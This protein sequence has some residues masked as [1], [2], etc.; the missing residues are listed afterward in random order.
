[1]SPQRA[2]TAVIGTMGDVSGLIAQVSGSG[3]HEVGIFEKISPKSR[4]L[5]KYAYVFTEDNLKSIKGAV[6]SVMWLAIVIIYFLVSFLYGGWTVTWLI[7]VVGAALTVAVNTAS[8]IMKYS[9]AGDD[10]ESRI[11]L[12]S[13]VEGGVT[14]IMWL[15]IVIVYFIGS[16]ASR[17]W[18][19]SWLIFVVGA[20]A[21]IIISL[22]FKIQ[23]SRFKN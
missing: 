18:D 12:L 19:I 6:I 17:R 22:V 15:A 16:F 23:K 13:T 1:M 2:F 11:K 20:A 14:S 3:V 5:E 9:R 7:F 10:P 4:L 21:Q 8:K